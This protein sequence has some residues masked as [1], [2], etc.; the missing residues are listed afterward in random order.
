MQAAIIWVHALAAMLIAGVAMGQARAVERRGRRRML[1]AGLML[2]ALW[3]L[4]VAGLGGADVGVWTLGS[5]RDVA[6]LGLL[7]A[8]TRASRWRIPAF[9]ATGSAMLVAMALR[10]AADLTDAPAALRAL[11]EAMRVFHMLAAAAAM[12]LAGRASVGERGRGGARLIVAT[13]ALLWGVD[14]VAD[15]LAWSAGGWRGGLTLARGMTIAAFGAS[16]GVALHRG[17]EWTLALSR[18]VA[19]RA[20]LGAMVVALLTGLIVAS[21]AVAALGGGS[22]RVAQTAFVVGTGAA[23]L[24]WISTPWLRAWVRVMVAKHLFTHRYDYRSAWI[25]FT[26][27][28]AAPGDASRPIA[29]RVVRAMA[30]LTEAPGALLLRVEAEGLSAGAEWNWGEV[31]R[32][33]AGGPLAAHLA[34]TGR[35]VALDEV[36]AGT[37]PLFEREAVPPWLLADAAAWAIVPLLHGDRLVGAMVLARPV[38]ARALD[39]ED[40]DLLGVAARQV[41]SHLAED[42]AHAALDQARRFEEFNRRFAFL[43][44]DLK[45]VVSQIALV[46]RNA[47]R[48]ADN[49]DFRADMIVTL[50][51]TSQRMTTLLAKLSQRSVGTVEPARTVAL[52]ALAERLADARRA[53]H[54]VHVEGGE[55][56]ARAQP[57]ALEALLG[58]LIQ[59]AIEASDAG[60]AVVLAIADEGNMASIEVIDRGC[61]MEPVFV[62]DRL[63]TPFAS[64]KP[65]GF[66]LGAYEARQL[67]V[68][69]GGSLSVDSRVG[70]GTRFRLILPRMAAMEQAA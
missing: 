25:G 28:L 63:F 39:W 29:E 40:L 69:M 67:A 53:Q 51:D 9:V 54:P 7:F 8:L 17:G 43:L 20:A 48:H 41:A 12:V 59:N 35:I 33:V 49:P 14:L 61:G 21:G 46:A 64:S 66:G 19:L 6:L 55:A 4:G 56:L 10:I 50:R 36:R 65:S 47:E 57:A 16:V 1:S 11:S 30:G 37:A 68:A 44:H 32:A 18:S 27:T 5:L 52:R 38:V 60:N 58:H 26:A 62:R 42:E 23:L 70:E 34:R 31:P 15:L 2:A 13:L 3:A 45:N 22:G 24:T